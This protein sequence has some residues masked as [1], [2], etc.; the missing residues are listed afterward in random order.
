MLVQ[1]RPSQSIRY[2]QWQA[3]AKVYWM[4]VLFGARLGY[5]YFNTFEINIVTRKF[6]DEPFLQGLIKFIGFFFIPQN[7]LLLIIIIISGYKYNVIER[8]LLLNI[9]IFVLVHIL[10]RMHAEYLTSVS[11]LFILLAA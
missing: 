7:F 3:L 10:S 4:F 9:V 8:F 11:G 5:F 6:I 2:R 1:D